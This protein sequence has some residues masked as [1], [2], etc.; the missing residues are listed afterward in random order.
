[1]KISV[2]AVLV[3]DYK[4]DLHNEILRNLGRGE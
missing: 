3:C 4:L 2:Y 1:M